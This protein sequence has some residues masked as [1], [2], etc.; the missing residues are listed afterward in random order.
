VAA[1][2]RLVTTRAGLVL[3]ELSAADAE[4]YHAIVQLSRDHLTAFGDYEGEV[5]ASL[6]EIRATLADAGERNLR[7]GIRFDGELVGRIDLVPVDPPRYAIGYWL[8]ANATGK[9]LATAA[10]ATLIDFA[11]EQRSATDI[12]AGVT[13]GNVKSVAVLERLG[14][15][16]VTEFE[17]YTRYHLPLSRLDGSFPPVLG[18]S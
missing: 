12:F 1:P 17:T 10:A 9:G 16:A 14:F 13:H 5:S 8:G 4:S 11:R 7:F 18:N 2:M 15:L 6:N 3:I